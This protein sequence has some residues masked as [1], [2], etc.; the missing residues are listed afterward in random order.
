M[1]VTVVD[2]DP[3]MQSSI[4]AKSMHAGARNVSDQHTGNVS[5]TLNNLLC[6]CIFH[7]FLFCVQHMLSCVD[8]SMYVSIHNP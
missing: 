5:L 8:I 2:D 6:I 7:V 3:R 1:T 4:V